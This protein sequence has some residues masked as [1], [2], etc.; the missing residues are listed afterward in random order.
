MWQQSEVAI[1]GHACRMP[2]ARNSNSFWHLLNTNRC[3]VTWI[4]PERFPT[5]PYHHPSL[6]QKGRS[7]TFAAGVIDDIWGFDAAAFGMSPREAEQVD[8][9]QR[10][11]L[12]VS[13]DALSHA[14]I[15]PS[16]LSGSDT[17]VYIGASSAD[18]AVRFFA[19]PSVA[20][21][22]MMTGNSVSIMANRISYTLNL[23]GPSI[24]FDTACS[25]SLV[26]LHLACEAIRSGSIDTAIVGGV[27]LL[28]SPFSY[29][30][31][32]QASMLSPTGLCRPFDAAADG[33]V[34]SEGVV[35][36]VL[37]SMAAAHKAR[38][39]IHGVVVGSG[40][41]Q[42]GRTT[43]LSLP[44]PKSQRALLEQVYG[45]F[46]VDPAD[47]LYVE[48]HGTGTRVGDP[49]EAD[50]LGK[51]LG[52]KRAQPLPIGSVKSNVGHLEPV[53]GLAGF[54][55][56]VL[57]LREGLIPA[58]LHQ[59]SPSADIPFDELNLRVVARNWR[60]PEQR[61]ATLVGVNSFGF[62]GTNAH[63]IL[64]SDNTNVR[65]VYW[66]SSSPPPPLLLT[67]HSAE[68]VPALAAAYDAS[69]PD[70]ARAA[71]ELISAS[72]HLRDLLPHRLLIRGGS[73]GEIRHH[74]HRVAEGENFD[75]ALAGQAIGNNLPIGFL[76]SGN[77][78]QWAG[79]GRDA[80]RGNPQF[81]E[82]LEEVDGH[83]A[84]VQKWSI[85]D[86]LFDDG[87]EGALREASFSQPLLLALQVAVVR[88]LEAGGVVPVATLG[89]SVGEI[90]AAWAAGALSL[91]QAIT[92]VGA[93]SRHQEAV[94][95][96][97]GMAAF[98]LSE[99]EARRFL[100]SV[101][102]NAV[103]I[104]AV[105]SWRSVTVSGPSADIDAVLA[106]ATKMRISGRR[107]DLDYPFHSALIDPVRAPLLRD[108]EG[109]KP[110]PARRRLVSSVT[111]DVVDAAALG[112]DYWW[113]NVREP[114]RFDAGLNRLLEQGVRIFVEVG[115][116][117]ILSSYVRDIL[118]EAGVRGA[119]VDTLSE[120]AAAQ[121]FDP[122]EHAVSKILLS[123]GTVDLARF[124]GPPP[125]TTMPLPLYPWQH[126]DFM[127]R[128]TLEASS[129]L[130]DGTHPLLGRKP[131]RACTEWFSTVDPQLF[132]W[133]EDHKFGGSR[134]FPAT[135]YI[136]AMFAAAREE[137]GDGPLELRDLDIFQ[138]LVFEGDT[139]YETLVRL[140][141]DTGVVEFLSR[142]RDRLPDW[143]LHARAVASRSPISGRLATAPEVAPETVSVAKTRVYEC[144]R[145]LGFDY[146][147]TFQ[148]TRLV[149]FPHPK[150]AVAP[151][152]RPA[153]PT[154]GPF[155]IDFTALDS[156][157][158]AL[159][160]S[161]EAGVAD[162][163]MR[164]ML[165]IR[166]GCLRSYV[167]GSAAAVATARTLKQSHTSLLVDIELY[168]SDGKLVL[169]AENV[170]L[171]NAPGEGA[172]DPSSLS[173]RTTVWHLER[174]GCPSSLPLV[175][176]R[177]SEAGFRRHR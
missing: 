129:A 9:Q 91:E 150:R 116:K 141:P 170:R 161:E 125:A 157:F 27:N 54:L 53:S 123:G 159:F 52:Q 35:V 139:S 110:L 108:L 67:A 144:A 68:A 89:H 16:S 20:D 14:G 175:P 34:R 117:P 174:A 38:N 102:A 121:R 50:A 114:V 163:P 49:I 36:V 39:H 138:P 82:A 45:R 6:G 112:P 24:A 136:E 64:R 177:R 85:I 73:V 137:L 81:R 145:A 93:R 48:A 90:A 46:G 134:L 8:P 146:G 60:L 26:A 33:Y 143:T 142:A 78:S 11:I 165:P 75:A 126:V 3:S 69:W 42:D 43:G 13:Y 99:R 95:H 21:V 140:A 120:H 98:M 25:S 132:P 104:A 107:L 151:L 168:D 133:L 84:K 96:G 79:M 57:A 22:H 162:M 169:G 4:T 32:S 103:E 130:S 30:G 167:P 122:I 94:R 1:V 97:G 12:E 149:A 40:I 166:F 28:L 111:G 109:L 113:R 15:P 55:K 171:M 72:A 100:S 164:P 155:V 10:H 124:F 83:F 19:D 160:A 47:L 92:V 118:R 80:W 172:A 154:T 63:A 148:R 119:V 61:G 62:G 31:F 41:N 147:P 77:G 152:E 87:L 76:F 58:T 2:G 17:G 29:I 106:A 37:R 156:A 128:P 105:N 7:Y 86:M 18:Y 56:S 158:H 153:A 176:L 135:G 70:D 44:S 66:R 173:Y 65:L 127:V 51:G 115:P 88:A 59:Q 23:R 74:L 71:G 5:R 131:R 101:Q